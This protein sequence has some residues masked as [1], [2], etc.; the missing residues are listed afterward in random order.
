MFMCGLVRLNEA[1]NLQG[2]A[3]TGDACT[4]ARGAAARGAHSVDNERSEG[5]ASRKAWAAFARVNARRKAETACMA[6]NPRSSLVAGLQMASRAASAAL[7]R[8][9]LQAAAS[10]QAAA[11]RRSSS[12]QQQQQQQAAEAAASSS[13]S[14]KQQQ[15]QQEG[16]ACSGSGSGSKQPPHVETI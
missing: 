6:S 3:S 8:G 9:S 16:G 11:A 10:K 2:R 12:K 4:V 13:S 1:I 5:A 14:S 7:Q 15:Q